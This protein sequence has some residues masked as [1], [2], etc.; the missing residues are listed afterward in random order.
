MKKLI[1]MLLCMSLCLGALAGCGSNAGSASTAAGSSAPADKTETTQTAAPET[2]T[3]A[4]AAEEEASQEESTGDFQIAQTKDL[5][6]A[7][8]VTTFTMWCGAPPG[9]AS[10]MG[11]PIMDYITEKTNI[12]LELLEQNMMSADEKFNLMIASQD[13]PD[14]ISGFEESYTGGAVK[15]YEDD[16]IVDLTDLMEEYAP[17]YMAYIQ[18]D[19]ENLRDAYNDDGQMLV[20]NGYNDEY[21]QARGS[22]IRL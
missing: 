12:S 10:V 14:I 11:S 9:G 20:M 1:T 18:Q 17:N 15:A 13:Y 22:V 8:E 19:Q 16:V 21:V 6:I 4:S 3:V 5:P 2:N 7:D